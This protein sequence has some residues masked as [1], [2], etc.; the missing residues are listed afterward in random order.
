VLSSSRKH[1]PGADGF[2]APRHAHVGDPACQAELLLARSGYPVLDRIHCDFDDG[3][4]LL[5]GQVPSY[6]LKQVA[7]EA[8]ADLVGVRVV[9]NELDV[10]AAGTS[11]EGDAR[12][13]APPVATPEGR[14]W[15]GR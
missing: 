9:R 5:R 4:L 6:Y 2:A 8:V 12:G 15:T 13:Q 7:Q 10:A 1:R 14:G 11:E 3:V